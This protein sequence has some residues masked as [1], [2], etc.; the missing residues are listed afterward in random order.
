MTNIKDKKECK[1]CLWKNN[2]NIN[3]CEQCGYR[4]VSIFKMLFLLKIKCKHANQRLRYCSRCG[5]RLNYHYKIGL[6]ENWTPNPYIDEKIERI[7]KKWY[8][9]WR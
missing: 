6:T 4:L 9:F 3:Y 7:R 8:Q 5:C 1:I 2:I